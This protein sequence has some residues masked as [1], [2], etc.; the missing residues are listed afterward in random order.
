VILGVSALLLPGIAFG[1]GPPVPA[2]LW[3]T[4]QPDK[5]KADDLAAKVLR[6][7]ENVPIALT[8][9]S[10]IQRP[11]MIVPQKYADVKA[12]AKAGLE[13]GGPGGRTVL[14]G[15]TLSAA[16]ISGG[17]WFMRRHGKAGKAL[18]VLFVFSSGLVFAPL[19]SE[20]SS[21]EAAPPRPQPK[22][23]ESLKYDETTAKLGV[24]VVIVAEGD[25][26]QFMLPKRLLPAVMI[27]EVE[28]TKKPAFP[29]M[30]LVPTL[31]EEKKKTNE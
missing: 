20:L 10:D 11:R 24:D 7:D 27:P 3:Y 2:P 15:L 6:T 8:F 13:N 25:R 5:K 23:L 26:I 31:P 14:A 29:G 1:N 21:N 4:R 16:F 28:F 12:P 18:L 22:T 19:L 9:R 30:G 17:F